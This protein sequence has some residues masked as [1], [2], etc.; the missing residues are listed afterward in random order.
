MVTLPDISTIVSW[1]EAHGKTVDLLK[2]FVLLLVAWLAG[3][4]SFVR[5]KLRT[6][7]ATIEEATSRCL[8]EE[9][10][11]FQGHKNAVR[12]TFLV[13]VGLLNPTSER[14]VVRHFS[15]AVQRRRVWRTWKPE[16]VALSLPSRPRHQTGSGSK[17]LKNWFSNFDDGLQNLTLLGTVE[18]KELPSGFLLFVCFSV[19]GWAPRISGEHIKVKAKVHLTT[20]EIYS[21]SG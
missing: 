1:I 6:P 7:S 14:V 9:F 11:E 18:P 20:G 8:V 15:L 3:A 21:A 13:E 2:W 10:A 4:F 12:A 17:V 5:S 16:L 19:G